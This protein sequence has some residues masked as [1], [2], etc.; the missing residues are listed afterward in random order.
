MGQEKMCAL[1]C[2]KIEEMKRR[3]KEGKQSQEEERICRSK[4]A[5]E[6]TRKG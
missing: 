6:T 3:K 5:N 1:M 4:K 2:V